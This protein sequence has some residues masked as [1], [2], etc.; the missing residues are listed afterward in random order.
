MKEADLRKWHRSLGII[1]VLF[2]ILQAGSGLLISIGQI[3]T[4]HSH[5]DSEIVAHAGPHEEGKFIIKTSLSFIHHGAGVVGL[6]YRILLGSGILGMS[7][8]G[9]M[10]YFKIRARNKREEK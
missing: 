1:L 10:I 4:S 6:I 2:I 5:A 3:G 9:S 8:T 7:I